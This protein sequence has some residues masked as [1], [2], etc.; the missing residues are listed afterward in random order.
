V[1]LCNLRIYLADKLSDTQAV[2]LSFIKTVGTLFGERAVICTGLTYQ[3][4]LHHENGTNTYI[5]NFL[6]F[7]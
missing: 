4:F 3:H 2:V 1:S 5:K 6:L 7:T